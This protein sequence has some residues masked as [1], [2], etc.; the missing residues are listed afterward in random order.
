[1]VVRR[2]YAFFSYI[3]G[4]LFG[5]RFIYGHGF[6]QSYLPVSENEHTIYSIF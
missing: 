2:V 4:K 1:M 6:E 3:R 5:C